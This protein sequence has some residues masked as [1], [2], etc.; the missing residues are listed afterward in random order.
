MNAVVFCCF[1]Q[2]VFSVSVG[3]L[4]PQ[5]KVLIKITYVVELTFE[6]DKI[7][8]NLPADVAP[9]DKDAALA[10]SVQVS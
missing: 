4:P 2:E 3:N 5:A 6:G 1:I 7:L 10:T 9:W 8:F